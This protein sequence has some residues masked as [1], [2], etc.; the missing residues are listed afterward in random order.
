MLALDLLAEPAHQSPDRLDPMRRMIRQPDLRI[1]D[2]W[3]LLAPTSRF[4]TTVVAERY[5]P[6]RY[7]QAAR[8]KECSGPY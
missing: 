2:P 6:R 7:N 8:H 3:R 1:R 5:V 4:S